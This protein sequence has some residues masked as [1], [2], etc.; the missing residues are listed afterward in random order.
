MGATQRRLSDECTF[1]MFQQDFGN[2]LPRAGP[3]QVSAPRQANNYW[4]SRQAN[5]YCP[6]QANNYC[7]RQANIYCHRQ[8][9]NYCPPS[10]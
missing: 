6:R 3:R 8:A 7:P 4:R 1:C 5:N 2:H 9:N 10:G